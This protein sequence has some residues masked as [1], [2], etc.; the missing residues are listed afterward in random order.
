MTDAVGNLL[1]EH[2]KSSTGS[3]TSAPS[4]PAG[5]GSD[6]RRTSSALGSPEHPALEPLSVSPP[7][8]MGVVPCGHGYGAIL[9]GAGAA[10]ESGSKRQSIARAS[11][12]SGTGT[13]YAATVD[14]IPGLE[15]HFGQVCTKEKKFLLWTRT[16]AKGLSGPALRE[17]K[18]KEKSGKGSLR[19]KKGAEEEDGEGGAMYRTRTPSTS[20]ITIGSHGEGTGKDSLLKYYSPEEEELMDDDYDEYDHDDEQVT[21]RESRR[22]SS[23]ASSI[24]SMVSGGLSFFRPLQQ[25]AFSFSTPPLSGSGSG[26]SYYVVTVSP[27]VQKY[28]RNTGIQTEPFPEEILIRLRLQSVQEEQLQQMQLQQ[29]QQQQQL[30]ESYQLRSV[31][32]DRRV[33]SD[34]SSVLPHHHLIPIDKA[35]LDPV[36]RS[37]GDGD[38]KLSSAQYVTSACDIDPATEKPVPTPAPSEG[39]GVTETDKKSEESGYSSS[40][41]DTVMRYLRM[42]RKNSKADTKETIDK[43][44]TVNYDRSLRYI[45]SK[46]VKVEEAL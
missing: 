14:D 30:Q 7:M 44:K 33:S 46:N 5:P 28:Y 34:D 4:T 29:K 20:S 2:H 16:R 26:D 37:D 9:A 6:S 35:G 45:K 31:Q 42:V 39:S 12:C 36:N 21:V 38:G 17:L 3:S 23:A 1:P 22:K 27:G 43:F 19:R 11:I 24:V 15:A 18:Q 25:Q 8:A 10:Y 41:S 40:I 32:Y 13:G